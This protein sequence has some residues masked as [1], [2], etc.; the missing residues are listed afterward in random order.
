[1]REKNLPERKRRIIVRFIFVAV[2]LLV[3]LLLVHCAG[4]GD[5]TDTARKRDFLW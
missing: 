5:V 4:I 2:M 1:M 3:V